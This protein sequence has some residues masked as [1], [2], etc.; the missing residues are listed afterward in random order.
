MFETQ[1][2][3][4]LVAD[5][6]ATRWPWLR[7]ALADLRADVVTATDGEDVLDHVDRRPPDAV[8]LSLKLSG[9]DALEVTAR[10]VGE[11]RTAH[12]PL[13]LATNDSRGDAKATAAL[14]AGAV[15][16][17][18]P[19]LPAAE[20]RAMLRNALRRKMAHDW[21]R[22]RELQAQRLAV[23]RDA[24]VRLALSDVETMLRAGSRAMEVVFDPT[25][26]DD[27][28]R[29]AHVAAAELA[30]ALTTVMTLGRIRAIEERQVRFEPAPCDIVD[31]VRRGLAD[32]LASSWSAVA[33]ALPDHLTITADG[34][35]LT[36]G[37]AALAGYLASCVKGGVPLEVT[38][39]PTATDGVRIE[40][41]VPAEA[42]ATPSEL[43]PIKA[44]LLL[45]LSRMV[46][47]A[48]GGLLTLS[49]ESEGRVVMELP[50]E[51]TAGLAW[52]PSSMVNMAG[53]RAGEPGT[54]AGVEAVDML[55][56]SRE[57]PSPPRPPR[58]PPPAPD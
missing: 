4:I 17:L 24:L 15:A 10:L 13:F 51:P 6:G 56:A 27:P 1:R 31:V 34:A 38:A 23:G 12:L 33:L 40:F 48:H 55:A 39:L 54:S 53:P 46:A 3:T 47:E 29:Y 7:S 18:G 28:E 30:D 22:R 11:P 9:L 50:A 20:L 37:L 49:V 26:N 35:L 41:A 57:L 52:P 2:A 19:A 14:E 32:P 36:N 25:E 5:A 16:L 8:V 44:A 58:L 45:T 42:A 43:D 21:H